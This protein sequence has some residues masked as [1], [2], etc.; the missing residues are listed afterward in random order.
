MSTFKVLPDFE[1]AMASVREYAPA[2][3]LEA[4]YR[5]HFERRPPRLAGR[6][7]RKP[8][9]LP[10]WRRRCATSARS[11]TEAGRREAAGLLPPSGAALMHRLAGH[12]LEP[13]GGLQIDWIG[14]AVLSASPC[15]GAAA[16]RLFL[17]GRRRTCRT[18][19][20]SRIQFAIDSYRRARSTFEERA[21]IV[22]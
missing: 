8:C 17:R 20:R 13:C 22:T 19:Y 9:S 10:H 11:R 14:N 5:A 6:T 18:L 1:V 21:D 15:C 3:S 2:V 12:R 16:R 4:D 7:A